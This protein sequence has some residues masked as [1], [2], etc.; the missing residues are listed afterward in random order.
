MMVIDAAKMIDPHEWMPSTMGERIERIVAVHHGHLRRELPRLQAL[1][2]KVAD[3]HGPRHP[4]L[5]ELR[6][7][8][9]SLR[10]ELDSHMLKEEWSLFPAIRR[11]ESEDT[12]GYLDARFEQAIADRENEHREVETAL[13]RMEGLL[14]KIVVTG[15]PNGSYH[16]LMEG[17]ASLKLDIRQH[18][19]EE[20]DV[21]FPL[22]RQA[23]A[24]VR[25]ESSKR[26][27][28]SA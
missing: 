24:S 3:L 14:R 26:A 2:E 28:S 20:G 8:F 5:G 22:A 7:I 25:A 11:L 19:H 6:E 15:D 12:L 9:R 18:H 23:A 21:L 16:A 1:A 17:L 10:A 27:R 13:E 4:E